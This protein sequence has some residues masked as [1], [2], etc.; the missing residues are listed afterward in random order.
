MTALVIVLAASLVTWLLRIGFITVLPAER[1]PAHIQRAFD[2][3]APAVLAAIVVSHVVHAGGP[4]EIP[5][6]TLA[7]VLAAA[8]VAWRSRNLALPVV[9]GV[10]VFGLMLAAPESEGTSAR[11]AEQDRVEVPSGRAATGRLSANPRPAQPHV[12]PPPGESR[13]RASGGPQP[14]GDR[15][16]ARTGRADPRSPGSSSPPRAARAPRPAAR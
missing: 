6:P 1:L 4:G 8:V 9:I 12:Q 2:D 13:R 7:S 3:V 10:A 5:W 11:D 15:P 14:R 16:S